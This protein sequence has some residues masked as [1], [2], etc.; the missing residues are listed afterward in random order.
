MIPH[1]VW[2]G[3]QEDVLA[4]QGMQVAGQVDEYKGLTFSLEQGPG[5]TEKRPVVEF[6]LAMVLA[7]EPQQVVQGLLRL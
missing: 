1:S 6:T 2:G 5:C 4:R 7:C 3:Q